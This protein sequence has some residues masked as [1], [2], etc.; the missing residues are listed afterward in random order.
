MT[1]GEKDMA[2]KQ[3]RRSTVEQAQSNIWQNISQTNG[4]RRENA[5]VLLEYLVIIAY[6]LVNARSFK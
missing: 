2:G 1:E 5:S 4:Q 3:K 6:I